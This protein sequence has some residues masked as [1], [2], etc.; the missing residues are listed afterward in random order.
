MRCS[1]FHTRLDGLVFVGN[2]K[3]GHLKIENVRRG[4]R[5]EAGDMRGGEGKW[6]EKVNQA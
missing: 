4:A 3:G 2:G 6:G 5:M 1:K